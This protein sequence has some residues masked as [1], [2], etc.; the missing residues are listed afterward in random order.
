MLRTAALLIAFVVALAGAR[1]ASADDAL[2]ADV[3][4]RLGENGGVRARYHERKTVSLL[5]APIES[6]GTLYFDPPDHLARHVEGAGGA[7]M[8]VAGD[9]VV[10]RD[11]TG[12]E[13]LRIGES[14]VARGLAESFSVALR[15]DLSLLGSRYE[16]EIQG[17]LASWRLRL[18]PRSR[19]LAR[20]VDRIVLEGSG[21]TLRRVELVE[22]GGDRTTTEFEDVATGVHFGPE[23]RARIF[24]IDRA[25]AR[26]D[27]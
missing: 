15:G 11:A 8:A 3:L 20:L 18:V 25:P 26:V 5:S 13:R 24:L 7:K 23:E 14:E 16:T 6:A 1:L 21:G 2:L 27:D 10:M 17:D 19:A 4:H 22:V 12:E 9:L